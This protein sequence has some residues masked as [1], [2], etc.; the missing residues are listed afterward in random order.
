MCRAYVL[1]CFLAGSRDF[2]ETSHLTLGI[3]ENNCISNNVKLFLQEKECAWGTL[4]IRVPVHEKHTYV[5]VCWDNKSDCVSSGRRRPMCAQCFAR[6]HVCMCL[7]LWARWLRLG[8]TWTL[9]LNVSGRSRGVEG[10]GGRGRVCA[11]RFIGF[12]QDHS[13]SL[14]PS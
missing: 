8:P 3:H 13:L 6:V 12:S 5:D 1:N 4:R 14:V 9:L 7:C 10:F 2:L 11:E